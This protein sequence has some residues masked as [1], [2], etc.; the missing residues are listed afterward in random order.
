MESVTRPRA[1]PERRA[2]I[3]RSVNYDRAIYQ[4]L[5]K[6]AL[7][8]NLSQGRRGYDATSRLSGRPKRRPA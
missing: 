7:N 4:N 5:T 2:Q 3:A 1:H 8:L 6:N